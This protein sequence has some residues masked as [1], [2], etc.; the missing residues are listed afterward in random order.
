MSLTPQPTPGAS[1][2]WPGVFVVRLCHKPVWLLLGLLIA[3]CTPAPDKAE[4]GEVS[5]TTTGSM[6]IKGSKVYHRACVACH[7]AG[8]VGAPKLGDRDAWAPRI[9]Q[10]RAVLLQH[11]L[12]GF[13]GETGIMPAKGGHRY[14]S[15]DEVAAALDFM[16]DAVP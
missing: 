12:D 13:K 11:A 6:M 2:R 5:V 16:L 14:L 3:G 8:L 15:E 9:A 4:V 7:G 10:G 1:R